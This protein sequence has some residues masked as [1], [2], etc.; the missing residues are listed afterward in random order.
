MTFL[1]SLIV[2]FHIEQFL[3]FDLQLI[4]VLVADSAWR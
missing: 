2:L 1:V 4:L 3:G